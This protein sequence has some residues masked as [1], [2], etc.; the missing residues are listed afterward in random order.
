[1][2]R[3]TARPSSVCL[4]HTCTST[5]AIVCNASCTVGQ[6]TC[7]CERHAMQGQRGQGLSEGWLRHLVTSGTNAR[8]KSTGHANDCHLTH[9][10]RVITTT[11]F[12]CGGA[13]P[14]EALGT[15]LKVLT[16]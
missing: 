15:L 13:Q 12:V 1:M 6:V 2:R 10:A 7:L 9:R 16:Q 11:T 5:R 14:S 3:P 8:H 4:L